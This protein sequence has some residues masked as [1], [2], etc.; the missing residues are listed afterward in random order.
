MKALY[1]RNNKKTTNV[2]NKETGINIKPPSA[3]ML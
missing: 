3:E 2:F 1:T